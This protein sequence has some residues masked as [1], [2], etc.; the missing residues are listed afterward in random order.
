MKKITSLILLIALIVSCF[1]SCTETEN[2]GSVD[3]PAE[4]EAITESSL[5]VE[6]SSEEE[7]SE[8]SEESIEIPD[9]NT[10]KVFYA[11]DCIGP[12]PDGSV[13][14]NDM[15][16]SLG[17]KS[18]YGFH[19]TYHNY[20][21]N[22][23]FKDSEEAKTSY[24]YVVV[25]LYS[26]DENVPKEPLNKFLEAYGFIVDE[27][28]TAA[29]EKV[30]GVAQAIVGYIPCIMLQEINSECVANKYNIYYSWLSKSCL[31]EDCEYYAPPLK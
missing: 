4:S 1:A 10:A 6:E 22:P 30:E 20:A 24:M 21:W 25:I 15:N 11:H 12:N 2:E 16:N 19:K 31:G 9:F 18:E 27:E 17:N 23:Y 13:E 28:N 3:T 26:S 29:L 5:T 7:N 14:M 8:Q